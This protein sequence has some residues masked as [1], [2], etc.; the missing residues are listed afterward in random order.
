MRTLTP[1]LLAFLLALVPADVAA[2]PVLVGGK[3]YRNLKLP[4]AVTSFLPLVQRV[5]QQERAPQ[6][7][8]VT[9][10]YCWQEGADP[11]QDFR[12]GSMRA[13]GLCSVQAQDYPGY[14]IR[15][16][17]DPVLNIRLTLREML[18]RWT[19]DPVTTATDTF[20]PRWRVF[21]GPAGQWSGPAEYQRALRAR[22]R[23]LETATRGDK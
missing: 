9:A 10:A 6:L 3:E 8:T 12:A 21:G 18:T 2:H 15:Q 11:R 19:G 17:L 7:A 22:I 23:L 13:I 16:L 20:L 5:A 14:S 4:A 1:W